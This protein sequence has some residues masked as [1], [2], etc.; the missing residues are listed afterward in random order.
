M[1]CGVGH[2]R[3]SDPKLLWL[4]YSPAA[5][6]PTGPLALEPPSAVGA[7]LKRQKRPKKEK[8]KKNQV[9]LDMIT[10]RSESEVALTASHFCLGMR[11]F[12]TQKLQSYHTGQIF[13]KPQ[14]MWK[15]EQIIIN[16]RRLEGEHME[17]GREGT[18]LA[19]GSEQI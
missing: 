3:G 16:E 18:S 19:W 6:T 14:V 9:K 12:H 4:W 10:H 1:S 17:T 7:A 5:A 15:E 11:L 8:K 13:M 2:R